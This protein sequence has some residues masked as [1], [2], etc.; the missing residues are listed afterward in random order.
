MSVRENLAP[1]QKLC[2]HTGEG[3]GWLTSWNTA[4]QEG[5]QGAGEQVKNEPVAL[6]AVSEAPPV[7]QGGELPSAQHWWGLTRSAVS[8]APQGKQDCNRF[9]RDRSPPEILKPN[10]MWPPAACSWWQLGA[11]VGLGGLQ[12]CYQPQCFCE[13][14]KFLRFSH[15]CG[16]ATRRYWPQSES[17]RLIFG[18]WAIC[19]LVYYSFNGCSLGTR[20]PSEEKP[21]MFYGNRNKFINLVLVQHRGRGIN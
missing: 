16:K 8:S 5:S 3:A 11:G 18:L 17:Y 20:M 15:C 10:W 1:W 9:P 12:I 4:V 19:I 21:K 2:T 7:R 6:W 13:Q 14:Q